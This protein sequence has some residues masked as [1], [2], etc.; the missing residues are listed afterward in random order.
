MTPQA[1]ERIP[2]LKIVE[3]KVTLRVRKGVSKVELKWMRTDVVS[4]MLFSNVIMWFIIAT[5]AS[6]LFSQSVTNIDSAP[7]AAQVLEPIAGHLA[8]VV[9]AA[10]LRGRSV[11]TISAMALLVSS[12]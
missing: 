8:Y 3:G 12:T 6:T 7:N 5:A 9:F 1:S 4:G 2:K 10:G 11:M